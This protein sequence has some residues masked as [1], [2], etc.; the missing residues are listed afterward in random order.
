MAIF[1]NNKINKINKISKIN[2]SSYDLKLRVL[3]L[4]GRRCGK[5]S[6]LAAM[7]KCFESTLGESDLTIS[8]SD[9]TTLDAIEEKN[10]EIENY[11][12]QAVHN[13]GFVPDNNPTRED[14]TYSFDVGLKG[15]R[16]KIQVEFYDYPGEWLNN[17][18]IIYLEDEIHNSDVIII[19]IDTP[20]M[21]EEEGVYNDKRNCCYRIT[22]L[23]KNHLQ[24]TEDHPKLIL[25]VPLKCE[26]YRDIESIMNMNDVRSAVQSKYETLINFFNR[27]NAHYCEVAITPIFTMGTAVFDRFVRNEQGEIDCN[28]QGIPKK[29]IYHFTT[30][31]YTNFI[32]RRPQPEYCEQPMLYILLYALTLV[33]QE[34]QKGLFSRKRFLTVSNKFCDFCKLASAS[35]YLE[36]KNKIHNKIILYK[37]GYYL[38][39]DPMSFFGGK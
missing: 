26:K 12:R 38:V 23:I 5:T 9:L 15:R 3:M 27:D 11:F 32:S 2:K 37:D 16:S 18:N 17:E 6:V 13:F 8:T 1:T 29:S 28:P 10:Q 14:K 30:A 21:L 25:F 34:K 24:P 35:D 22:E 33:A 4:G 31:A 20:H 19:T 7:Q 36:Q 39:N